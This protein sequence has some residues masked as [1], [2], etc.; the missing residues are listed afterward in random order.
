MKNLDKNKSV[1]PS[2]ES[3]DKQPAHG[4]TPGTGTDHGGRSGGIYDGTTEGPAPTTEGG[5]TEPKTEE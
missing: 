2:W 5:A 3:D 4:H 1:M